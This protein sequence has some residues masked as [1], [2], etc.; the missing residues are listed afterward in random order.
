[1]RSGRA[2]A[3]SWLGQFVSTLGSG[4]T[5]FAVGVDVYRTTGS[6]TQ[7]G[8]ITF[9]FVLPTMLLSPFAGVFVDRWDRRRVMLVSDLVAAVAPLWIFGLLAAEGAGLMRVATWQFYAPIFIGSATEA[10]RWP[11]YYATAT[12]LVPRE[13]LGRASGMI[14]LG[15]AA[16][17]VGA[18]LLAALL[19][20]RAGLPTVVLLDFLSFLFA[21][22]TL[23]VVRFP[24]P[25]ASDEGRASRGSLGREIGF[26]WR[27][28]VERPGL[29]RLV[30][31]SAGVNFLLGLVM[32]LITPLALSFTTITV[33]GEIQSA[34]GVGAVVGG[35]AMSVWG[36]PRRRVAG[37]LWLLLLAGAVLF[38]AGLP[39]RAWVVGGAAA[40]FMFTVP[41]IV[42]CLQPIW[43]VKVAPDVQ[44]RV[45]AVRRALGTATSPLA[46]LLA[47]PLGEKVFEPWLAPGGLLA[48]SVGR[49][50]GVGPGRG[51]GLLF[52][53]LGAATALGVL[54]AA[55]SR[56]LM[57]V[58]TALPDA[59]PAAP[60]PT[61]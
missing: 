14:E 29:V 10:F 59:L 28:I 20:Q 52:I 6:M 50:I 58:E 54:L 27:F 8:L 44:G 13:Q 22:L 16:A 49:F 35:V 32:V 57:E 39:P 19:L 12:L 40:A 33:L 42:G 17:T 2:F 43:Q 61:A 25:P 56:P 45:F 1:M 26:G 48:D 23:L 53:V 38:A 3:I 21:V 7:L 46:M 15:S 24:R 4:L 30:Y 37:I 55:R 31:V 11:A 9:F 51:I 47:G 60:A 34:A 41:M 5:G 36:G 18:P